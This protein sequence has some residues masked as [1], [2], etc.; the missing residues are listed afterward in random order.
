M[1]HRMGH[2]PVAAVRPSCTGLCPQRVWGG[3]D[4][5]AQADGTVPCRMGHSPEAI[6]HG[7][8]SPESVGPSYTG[9]CPQRVCGGGETAGRRQTAGSACVK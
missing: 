6:L 7:T 3:W 9:L 5:G 4:H 8:V 2:S 1:G